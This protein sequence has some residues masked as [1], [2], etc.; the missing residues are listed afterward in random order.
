MNPLRRTAL[1]SAAL[2]ALIAP[3]ACGE[4]AADDPAPPAQDAGAEDAAGDDAPDAPPPTPTMLSFDEHIAP[5]MVRNR[6]V[7]CHGGIAGYYAER[8]N[9]V[10][11]SGNRAPHVVP[12]DPDAS[13]LLQKVLPDGPWPYGGRMPTNAPFMPEEDVAILRQWIAEGAQEVYT[14][15]FCDG[16]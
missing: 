7:G 12:C 5:L 16:R 8:H 15:G 2:L 13:T 3:A 11:G 4:D 9:D 14:P 10:V 1:L 6:C